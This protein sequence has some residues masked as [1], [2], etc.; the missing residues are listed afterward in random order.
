MIQNTRFALVTALCALLYGIFPGFADIVHLKNGST[1]EGNVVREGETVRIEFP[2]GSMEIS[3]DEVERVEEKETP[4]QT[5]KDKK[6][7]IDAD[8]PK[9][10]YELAK[11]CRSEGLHGYWLDELERTIELDPDHEAARKAR[12]YV[13]IDDAWI[14]KEEARRVRSEKRAQAQREKAEQAAKGAKEESTREAQRHEDKKTADAAVPRNSFV[15]RLIASRQP[16]R[17]YTSPEGGYVG[18]TLPRVGY[19]GPSLVPFGDS[20]LVFSL[21]G[22]QHPFGFGRSQFIPHHHIGHPHSLR[23]DH[24]GGHFHLDFRHRHGRGSLSI[25]GHHSERR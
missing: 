6:N 8:D 23:R 24:L 19:Y 9:A 7:E 17:R 12:G 13:R 14:T 22:V 4:A 21:G 1:L 15:N 11:W 10:H 3:T 5:Y 20:G 25:G 2:H 18:A 16:P